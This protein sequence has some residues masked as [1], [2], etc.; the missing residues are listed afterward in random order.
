MEAGGV[1]PFIEYACCNRILCIRMSPSKFLRRII[2]MLK[3]K[4]KKEASQMICDMGI[5]GC[6]ADE[7]RNAEKKYGWLFHL[8]LLVREEV[9]ISRP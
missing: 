1:R 8:E 2:Q 4:W 7:K 9:A 6:D 5:L 3:L